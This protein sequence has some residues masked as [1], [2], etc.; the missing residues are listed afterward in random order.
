MNQKIKPYIM[1]AR[2]ANIAL[3]TTV[4]LIT[5]AFFSPYP[6]VW[7][8]LL[9]VLCVACITAAGNTL[10]DLFDI[11]IDR[12]N[13][14]KRPLPSGTILPENA[15]R[16]MYVLFVLGNVFALILGFWNLVISLIIVTLS[17]YWYAR[18]LRN[19]PLAG[20]VMVAFLSS[21]TF[22]FAALAFKD[23]SMAYIPALYCFMISLIREIVKDLEDL[24][25]DGINNSNTLPVA[26][27]ET[28]A[29]VIAAIMILFFLPIIP[30]PYLA[31]LYNQWFFFIA[32]FAVGVPMVIIMVKLFQVRHEVNYYQFASIMKIIMFIGLL[33]LFIGRL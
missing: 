10:N 3:V 4:I 18:R 29:R 1:L 26:V 27:G 25:G 22:V 31:G 21:L 20:N 2:P 19:V 33:G 9:S 28:S 32:V 17:L 7:K 15:K 11:E 13:K 12:I 6:P 5:S 8:V 14:P 24:R 16:Y 30:L 23:I